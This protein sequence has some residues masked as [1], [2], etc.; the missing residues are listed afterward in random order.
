[1]TSFKM[2]VE[3]RE[4]SRLFVCQIQMVGCLFTLVLCIS[5]SMALQIFVFFL[6]P[7][8]VVAENNTCPLYFSGYDGSCMVGS[9]FQDGDVIFGIM[10]NLH[11]TNHPSPWCGTISTTHVE[12]TEMV[13]WVLMKLREYVNGVTFGK[14]LW[15]KKRKPF[16]LKD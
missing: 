4:I 11:E 5:A 1:M 2:A 7:L 9:E 8:L 3:I 15:I 10:G 13:R 12:T 14:N 6:I 16:K